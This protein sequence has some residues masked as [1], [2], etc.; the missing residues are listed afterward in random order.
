[1]SY[2]EPI[3]GLIFVKSVPGKTK[4]VLRWI[5]RRGKRPSEAKEN[6]D[7]DYWDKE[8]KRVYLATGEYDIIVRVETKDAKRL[9]ELADIIGATRSDPNVSSTRTILLCPK[10]AGDP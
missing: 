2:E 10:K 7:D 3:E 8:I 9:F 4:H 1:M 6:G 5:A